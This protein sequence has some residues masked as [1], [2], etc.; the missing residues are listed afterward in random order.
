MVGIDHNASVVAAARA[1]AD[2]AGHRNVD[3]REHSVASFSDQDGFDLVVGRYVFVHQDD[4]AAFL[5]R[6]RSFVRSGGALA[7]H[8]PSLL[9]GQFSTPPVDL[10][11]NMFDAM[12]RIFPVVTPH[13]DAPRYFLSYFYEAGL[14]EPSLFSE[15]P[16][17]GGE[18]SRFYAWVADTFRSTR[19]MIEKHGLWR[20][21]AMPGDDVER[22]LR[23]ACVSLHSQVR[24]NHQIC[25]WVKLLSA[26]IKCRRRH[27][28]CQGSGSGAYACLIVSHCVALMEITL[29]RE[30]ACSGASLAGKEKSWAEGRLGGRDKTAASLG[31]SGGEEVAIKQALSIPLSARYLSR[32]AGA[33]AS[34]PRCNKDLCASYPP[35]GTGAETVTARDDDPRVRPGRVGNTGRGGGRP[36]SFVGQVMR[37]ARKA[38]HT[39][40]GL[41][42]GRR[43]GAPGFGRGRAAAA[44]MALRSPQRRVVIKARVVR[45]RGSAFRSAPL[46]KHVSYLQRDGVT[47]DGTDAR[48]FDARGDE[49]DPS[50]FAERCEGDRHHFRFIVSPEDAPDMADLRGFTRDL[51]ARAEQD[52]GTK[53]DWAAVYHWYTD[54]PHVHV[55]ARGVAEDGSDLVISREYISRGLRGRAEQLVGLELGPRSEH[56]IRSSLEREVEAERWTGLD[57]ALRAA[58]DDGGGVVDLRPGESMPDPELRRMMIGRAQTL[59]RLGLAEPAGPAAW[60][61]KADF[62]PTLCAMGDRGDIIKSMHRALSRGG[63]QPSV[64]EFAIHGEDAP[65]VLGRLADRGLHDELKGSAYVVIEGVDGRSHHLRFVNLEATGDAG[66]GAIVE[67]R[68]FTG[69]DGRRL[70]LSVRSDLSLQAQ[71]SSIGATWLDRTLVARERAPFAHGGF[72]AEV[73]EAL[74]RRSDHLAAEGLARRQGQRTVFARDLLDTLS[75]RELDAVAARLSAKTGLLRQVAAEGEHVAGIYRQRVQV[76]SGRFA[77]ID[78]G[79]GFELVPWR[80]ALEQHLGRQVSGVV[81]PSGGVDWSFG[82]KRGL[83]VG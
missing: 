62:E 82:R 80:P 49:V 36:Q 24:L 9:P 17:G 4:P 52:L 74:E 46:A 72:G 32:L 28:A 10:Y 39:G 45:Q 5:R 48:S 54:Q 61:L 12:M 23:A 71:V 43:S 55:L 70:S 78:N 37:A 57:R 77:M 79:L 8:E 68:P 7:F 44:A 73:R 6:A 47:K 31:C 26:G 16:V 18:H 58:A 1:R 64:G 19:P 2:A 59:E 27:G 22:D 13:Y 75:R 21:G 67:A 15:T 42:R 66:V 56:A 30:L 76:A 38:W 81:Q 60:T 20:H 63:R 53:I 83:G 69:D 34:N 40:P 29:W 33:H 14:P 51:M 3:F 35:V 41:G 25:A 50:A 65:A 11:E